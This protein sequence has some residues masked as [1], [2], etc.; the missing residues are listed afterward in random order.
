MK[1]DGSLGFFILGNHTHRSIVFDGL[2]SRPVDCPTGRSRI[3]RPFGSSGSVCRRKTG[4]WVFLKKEKTPVGNASAEYLKQYHAWYAGNPDEKVI[5]LTFDAGYENGNT[6]PIL[7]AL[8]KHHAPAAFFLVGNYLE[9]SPELVKRM[10]SEGHIVGNH[11]YHHPD[12]SKIS[13]KEAFQ[14][15]LSDLETLYEQTT[16]QKMKRYYRPLRKIQ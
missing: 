16:G 12:M 6:E 8:K 14:K 10:V 11:T 15:E 5:Y 3:F 1:N 4:V 2:R 13:S 7:D 9:T